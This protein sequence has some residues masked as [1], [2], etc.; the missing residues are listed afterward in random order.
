VELVDV[1]DGWLWHNGKIDSL[2]ELVVTEPS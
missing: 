2:P 1:V